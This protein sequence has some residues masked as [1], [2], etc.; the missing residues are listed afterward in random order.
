MFCTCYA[1][2]VL[3][4]L[5]VLLKECKVKN[6]FL[7]KV[8]FFRETKDQIIPELK[9]EC[10]SIML[11]TLPFFIVH[12]RI[13]LRFFSL[14]PPLTCSFLERLSCIYLSSKVEAC[15]VQ[16]CIRIYAFFLQQISPALN[17]TRL[18]VSGAK[19]SG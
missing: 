19:A 5:Y 14:F 18:Q 13:N 10:L 4:N 6:A 7:K 17:Y 2:F 12:L 16:Q 3:C 8:H 15:K 11:T 1:A 9:G